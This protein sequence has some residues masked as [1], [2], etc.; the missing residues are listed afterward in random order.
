MYLHRATSFA[1]AGMGG[2]HNSQQAHSIISIMLQLGTATPC[3][4]AHIT[5][6]FRH[7]SRTTG[8][9][10]TTLVQALTLE[11]AK[12]PCRAGDSQ[13]C[14]APAPSK[15]PVRG[16]TLLLRPLG[17]CSVNYPLCHGPTGRYPAAQQ[18][19]G[20]IFGVCETRR[21]APDRFDL[22]A[23]WDPPCAAA[24][25][26]EPQLPDMAHLDLPARLRIATCLGCWR[27]WR[28]PSQPS[29]MVTGG[30]Q[31][32]SNQALLALRDGL[33]AR[34]EQRADAPA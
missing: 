9:D 1:Q 22:A 26:V 16:P 12:A 5:G 34:L 15:A 13:R 17:P 11:R 6:A 33:L 14:S 18:V 32:A 29:H 20:P 2:Q 7:R 3:T 19:R 21:T 23:L 8:V 25:Q 31:T 4:L 10:I 24:V 28:R 30:M 27:A